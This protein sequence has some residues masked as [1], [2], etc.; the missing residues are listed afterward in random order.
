MRF[1]STADE[2]IAALG[3]VGLQYEAPNGLE[4]RQ[5]YSYIDPA[6]AYFSG[7]KQSTKVN[8]EK[9]LAQAWGRNLSPKDVLVRYLR[10]IHVIQQWDPDRWAQEPCAPELATAIRSV[11]TN[12]V[13]GWLEVRGWDVTDVMSW[14]WIL[15]AGTAERAVLRLE[16]L[17]AEERDNDAGR[18]DIPQFLLLI[19]L[20]RR[21]TTFAFE[22]LLEYTRSYMDSLFF[23]R[24]HSLQSATRADLIPSPKD[25]LVGMY[26]FIFMMLIV[27][28][29]RGAKRVQPAAFPAIADLFCRYM[30]G[31]NFQTKDQLVRLQEDPT[32]E[33]APLSFMYNRVLKLIGEPVTSN[34]VEA[35][36]FQ[37]QAQFAVVERMD[38]FQPPLVV[39]Q[40]GYRAIT[41][42]LILS[43]KTDD[44]RSWAELKR[45]S[46]PPW[47]EEKLGIH[48]DIGWQYGVSQAS[49]VLRRA[50]EAGYSGSMW[51]TRAEI[52]AGWDADNTP[53]IQSRDVLPVSERRSASGTSD[54]D[55]ASGWAARIKATRTIDESWAA[56]SRWKVQRRL[57]AG[58]KIVYEAMFLQ[59]SRAE[60][61]RIS[62]SPSKRLATSTKIPDVPELLRNMSEDGVKM[63]S[64]LACRLLRGARS[65]S[66]I[67]TILEQ[68]HISLDD[69]LKYP[70]GIKRLAPMKASA[71]VE[72]IA[73][74]GMKWSRAEPKADLTDL[75]DV[76]EQN[77]L[78]QAIQLALARDFETIQ[79]W[80]PILA[81]LATAESGVSLEDDFADT[82]RHKITNWETMRRIWQTL[83]QRPRAFNL[84]AFR[85][86]SIALS[87]AFQQSAEM[88]HEWHG[89]DQLPSSMHDRVR[90]VL[91]DGPPLLNQMFRQLVQPSNSRADQALS[92]ISDLREIP[93][94][95]MLH[96][97]IR[98]LGFA[99]DFVT[100]RDLA[101]LILK[102]GDSILAQ[103][104]EIRDSPATVNTESRMCIVA[105]R[106]FLERNW[107]FHPKG[108]W[109]NL[110]WLDRVA[111]TW[112]SAE[113]EGETPETVLAET[114]DLQ[115]GRD[116]DPEIESKMSPEITATS[117]PQPKPEDVASG[118]SD[119]EIDT[120]RDPG[121]LDKGPKVG[122]AEWY[123]IIMA[124]RHIRDT[125]QNIVQ[126]QQMEAW[127]GWPADAEVMEYLGYEHSTLR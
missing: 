55:I 116:V 87:R 6:V 67:T 34:P 25:D 36:I 31:K 39:S 22:R 108:A 21:T 101:I 85:Y 90:S 86:F 64:R 27:R 109:R 122:S 41:S 12:H 35:A 53:T 57:K 24:P 105:L 47:K 110:V 96:R 97:Y 45:L 59:L 38:Q 82:T 33:H 13:N 8:E 3:G 66:F 43:K 48:A 88:V 61:R 84:R 44:E 69:L 32:I 49:R 118:S 51:E 68:I 102:H 83:D 52:L 119:H 77:P 80:L 104:H 124:P 37:R 29:L 127:G 115:L 56:F 107:T 23:V 65:R 73:R 2:L 76:P 50:N 60:N 78:K 40:E 30:D 89:V 17:A 71:V 93:S 14:A 10:H 15:S 114:Q 46:W 11:F 1:N 16:R 54:A 5:S 62:E 126:L 121:P 120:G 117:A 26:N 70:D 95:G 91:T 113:V 111:D 103:A 58:A 125:I 4:R 92:H 63:T 100:M 81:V 18:P 20:R 75:L 28:L 98:A 112:C 9:T 19:L 99:R 79:P 106:V 74:Q 94:L 123:E 7:K 42:T 72:A